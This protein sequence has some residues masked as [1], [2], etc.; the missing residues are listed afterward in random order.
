[1]K[2]HKLLFL[3]PLLV[4]LTSCITT[5]D[6]RYLQPN[7]SLQLN[8]EGLVSYENIPQYRI[9]KND[10]LKL[11]IITTPKGDA[12]QFYSTMYAAQNS[13]GSNSGSSSGSG[14]SNFYF[15]GLKLDENGEVY[16]FGIGKMKAEGKTTQQ[17]SQEIQEKVNENFLPEKS[18][19]R[20]FLEG[21]KYTML[22]DIDGQSVNKTVMQPTLTIY[23]AIAE[24]GG[25]DRRIDRKNVVVY[26][27][28]PEG[29]KKAQIDLTRE[30][31]QNS[32]Y[33]WVQ[34]GD[35]IMFNTRAK[36]FYG[37]GKEPIQT[38]TTGVTLLTTALSIYLLFSKL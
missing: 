22:F 9:T 38:L 25:L 18:E 4:L 13:G 10:M 3:I 34:N 16:I 32:P 7:E 23:E 2:K 27:K 15:N 28:F 17:L 6:V 1:M 14:S 26:R 31:I 12:A 35:L 21:I 8:S 20:I 19:V 24:S 37:F 11:N 36:S 5:K 30:D 33:F 29:I